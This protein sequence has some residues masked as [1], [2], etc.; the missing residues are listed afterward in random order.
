MN[1]DH[2]HCNCQLKFLVGD[3][4]R[5]PGETSGLVLPIRILGDRICDTYKKAILPNFLLL[6]LLER[7]LLILSVILLLALLLTQ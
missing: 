3:L 5:L 1:C 2:S 7:H 4:F 6:T